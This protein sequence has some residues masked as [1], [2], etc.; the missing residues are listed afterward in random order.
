[1]KLT[2][3]ALGNEGRRE[4]FEPVTQRPAM[5]RALSL[6]K[7]LA[8]IIRWHIIQLLKVGL[9]PLRVSNYYLM[10]A[11]VLDELFRT[12]DRNSIGQ[13]KKNIG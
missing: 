5:G 9:M 10:K 13:Y 8:N 12:L 7:C 11:K 1:M 6:G 4:N 2:T 3:V